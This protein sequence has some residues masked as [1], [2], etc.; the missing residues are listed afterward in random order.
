LI[1]PRPL[2]ASRPERR[3]GRTTLQL[4]RP[5]K[6]RRAWKLFGL[7]YLALIVAAL[8][9]VVPDSDPWV[10]LGGFGIIFAWIGGFVHALII[11]STY[12][13][14][15]HSPEQTLLDA[16]EAR[17][18]VREDAL[19]LAWVGRTLNLPSTAAWSTSTAR[20]PKSSHGCPTPT[21]GWPNELSS[22]ANAWAAS[23]RSKTWACCSI[24]QPPC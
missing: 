9:L 16:G 1:Q 14:L 23:H 5:H 8:A 21:S 22:C 6:R 12:L 11:R 3:F 17:L 7:G 15:V 13:K 4:A 19:Q 20:R 2:G 24:C 18:R 10:T